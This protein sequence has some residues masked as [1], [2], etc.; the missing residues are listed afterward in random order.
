MTS[1]NAGCWFPESG[2]DVEGYGVDPDYDVENAPH[3]MVAGRDPAIG[4]RDRRDSQ[5]AGER[6]A[7][8]ATEAGRIRIARE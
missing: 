3:E 6:A 7:N 1:P 8:T 4:N 5:A 2:F